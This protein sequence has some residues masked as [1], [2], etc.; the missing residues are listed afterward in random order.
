MTTAL[1]HDPSGWDIRWSDKLAERYRAEGHWLDTTL[2]DT[3]RAAVAADPTRTLLIEGDRHLTRGKAWDQA[4][5]VA[6][7]FVSRGLKPGDVVSFQLP[8][9]TEAAIL[10]LAA[11]MVGVVINP[12][13]PIYR[14]SE[15][16]Y[17]LTDSASKVIFIPEVFR[18]HDHRGML[19]TLRTPSRRLPVSSWCEERATSPGTT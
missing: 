11:R 18:K 14:E 19:E 16:A 3:A 15:L 1:E 2:V 6:G 4:L 8:N 10:A 5:R 17:I 13:P 12:I 7:F 9:W